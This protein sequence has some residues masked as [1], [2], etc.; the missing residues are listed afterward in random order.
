VPHR[1]RLSAI[2]T[3]IFS[4]AFCAIVFRQHRKRHFINESLRLISERIAR[5]SRPTTVAMFKAV[6]DLFVGGAERWWSSSNGIRSNR[7]DEL[8]FAISG[9]ITNHVLSHETENWLG[10]FEEL[11]VLAIRV[12]TNSRLTAAEKTA[13]NQRLIDHVTDLEKLWQ[14]LKMKPNSVSSAANDDYVNDIEV[15]PLAPIQE[16]N[17]RAAGATPLTLRTAARPF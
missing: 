8:Y 3:L 12:V 1:Q 4:L 15:P 17:A 16:P 5:R 11:R 14:I 2:R 13:L 10:Y 9:L 7:V 6:V